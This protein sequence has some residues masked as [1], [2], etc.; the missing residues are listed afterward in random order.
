MIKNNR[1]AALAYTVMLTLVIFTMCTAILTIMLAQIN[2]SDI[3]KNNAER[4]RVCTQIGEAYCGANGDNMAFL[5]ALKEQEFTVE[6][7]GGKITA[8]R[9]EMTFMLDFNE[10]GGVKTLTVYNQNGS[11]IYLRVGITDNKVTE[12]TKGAADGDG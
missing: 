5:A 4:E 2:D 6:E 11:D 8:T 9:L 12:W 7:D 10:D 3:Y 1:G